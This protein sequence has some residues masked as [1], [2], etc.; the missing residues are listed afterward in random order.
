MPVVFMQSTPETE[1][2]PKNRMSSFGFLGNLVNLYS[3]L[4][5]N[6]HITI[7]R[8]NIDTFLNLNIIHHGKQKIKIKNIGKLKQ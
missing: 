6:W 3:L 2:I 7:K 8:E 5:F 1:C 4:I